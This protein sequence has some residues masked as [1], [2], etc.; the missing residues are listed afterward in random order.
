MELLAL[1]GDQPTR[2]GQYDHNGRVLQ[3][4]GEIMMKQHFLTVYKKWKHI[5]NRGM[6]HG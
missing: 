3:S 5:Y 4:M 1:P 6:D 2:L